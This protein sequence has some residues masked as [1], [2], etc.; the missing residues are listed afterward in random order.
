MMQ[1]D[2]MLYS[3][4]IVMHQIRCVPFQ[5]ANYLRGC[6]PAAMNTAKN[7]KPHHKSVIYVAEI[8]H[9][10]EYRDNES[11]IVSEALHTKLQF[12]W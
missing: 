3:G 8:D 5:D 7:F 4:D 11:T 2:G 1:Q 10:S 12:F 9:G 6:G